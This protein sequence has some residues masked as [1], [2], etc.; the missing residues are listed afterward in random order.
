MKYRV[1]CTVDSA[2][3]ID[4]EF[5]VEVA[6]LVYTFTPDEHGRL[7]RMSITAQV[8]DVEK[9]RSEIIENPRPGVKAH[10]IHNVDKQLFDRIIS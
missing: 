4:G 7:V 1:T 8:P 10:F 3:Y 9:F 6:D 5:N 2:T